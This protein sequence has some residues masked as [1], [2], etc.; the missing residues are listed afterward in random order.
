MFSPHKKQLDHELKI[1]LNGKKLY[2]T[3]SVKYV[4]IHLVNPVDTGRKLNVYNVRSY[5]R[6][7][8]VLCLLGKYLGNIK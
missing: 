2:Q 8:Y 6:S 3:D 1:K 5:L 7:I 4:G